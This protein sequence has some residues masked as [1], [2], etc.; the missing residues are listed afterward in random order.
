VLHLNAQET[1]DFVENLDSSP[2]TVKIS[3]LGQNRTSANSNIG[4]K[5][6]ASVMRISSWAQIASVIRDM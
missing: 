4:Y 6:V 3:N 1:I 5:W 2:G